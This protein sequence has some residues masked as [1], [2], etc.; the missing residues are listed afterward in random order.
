MLCFSDKLTGTMSAPDVTQEM[1]ISNDVA[2]SVI[3]KS[4]SKVTHYIIFL[5]HALLFAVSQV[6]EIR[7][8]SGAG[9]HIST[10]D[11][12]TPAGERVVTMSGSPVSSWHSSFE[13]KSKSM[14]I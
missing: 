7:K 4:G 14:L 11:E 2:G 1:M 13:H 3:G 5:Y 6:A 12:V 8:I 10:E 9:V